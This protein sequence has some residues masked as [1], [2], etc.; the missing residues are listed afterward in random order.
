MHSQGP[1]FSVFVAHWHASVL[2]T[3]LQLTTHDCHLYVS[4][5]SAGACRLGK[6]QVSG[7][8]AFG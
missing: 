6:G 3:C 7:A 4:K 2:N 8:F 5:V 1:A